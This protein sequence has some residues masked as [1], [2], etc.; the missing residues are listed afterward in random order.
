MAPV[1]PWEMQK[2]G[3]G[4]PPVRL[5]YGSVLPYHAVS[6][7]NGQVRYCLG[8]AILDLERPSHVLYRT[9]HPILEPQAEYE[10][11]GHVNNIAFPTAGDLR[12][13]RLLDV[14]YG[15]ADRVIAAARVTLP[16][17]LPVREFE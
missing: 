7:L 14:Y 16:N 13:D 3:A 6:V 15:A 2:I 1:E 12:P 10:R 8:M 11:N 5:P 4:A 17:H 9:L